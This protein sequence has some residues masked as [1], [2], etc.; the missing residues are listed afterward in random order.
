MRIFSLWLIAAGCQGSTERVVASNAAWAPDDSSVLVAASSRMTRSTAPWYADPQARGWEVVFARHTPSLGGRTELARFDDFSQGQGGGILSAQLWWLADREQVVALEY[1]QA[2]VYD[3][4]ALRRITLELPASERNRLFNARGLDLRDF[5]SPV[6][7]APSPDGATVA[8]HYTAAFLPGGPLGDMDFYHAV[9]F[10]DVDGTFRVANDLAPF[11]GGPHQLRRLPPEPEPRYPTVEPPAHQ[12]L[13]IVP[14]QHVV[15]FV[16]ERGGEGVVFVSP[17][18]AVRVDRATG[19]R[20][21]IALVPPIGLG[22]PGGPVSAIGDYLLV[23]EPEGD[24]DAATITRFRSDVH[25]PWG[26]GPD[27][28]LSEIGWVY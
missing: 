13:S 1:H 24:P 27:V 11:R 6:M 5:A 28:P 17:D 14:T 18:V 16:W 12:R 2:V 23:D 19:T 4:A 10:F 26:A 7:V 15:T 22:A 25:R 8:V 9:A 21:Q 20:T 3:L